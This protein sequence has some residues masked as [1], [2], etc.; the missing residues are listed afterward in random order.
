MRTLMSSS[1]SRHRPP[2]FSQVYQNQPLSGLAK[3]DGESPAKG[4]VV[5]VSRPAN[6][7]NKE[8]VCDTYR[9]P[10]LVHPIL[11]IHVPW[12]RPGSSPP[13]PQG[14]NA[15]R[16]PSSR[17]RTQPDFPSLQ[18]QSRDPTSVLGLANDRLQWRRASKQ[19]APHWVR[20]EF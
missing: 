6:R 8:E 14:E 7:G 4:P 20:H 13:R 10:L 3:I 12:S 16:C 19:L 15:I 11:E 9:S 2:L 5:S 18:P 17:S 1:E